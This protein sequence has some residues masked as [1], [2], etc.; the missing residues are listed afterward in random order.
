MISKN[1]IFAKL[2]LCAA[3]VFAATALAAAA[4]AQVTSQA[5]VLRITTGATDD[6]FKVVSGPVAGEVQLFEVPGAVDGALY[7]GVQRI[8][9][10]TN[11]G[12]DKITVETLSATVPQLAINAGAG[13]NE[14]VVLMSVPPSATP[15]TSTAAVLGGGGNDYIW[16]QATSAASNLNLVWDVFAGGGNNI[17]LAEALSDGPSQ[18]LSLDL[19]TQAGLGIDSATVNVDS[20]AAKLALL[21]DGGLGS[22][23]NQYAVNAKGAGASTTANLRTGLG[24]GAG[25]DNVLLELTEVGQTV[26][27]GGLSTGFGNDEVVAKFPQGLTGLWRIDTLAGAD[28]VSVFTQGAL[29]GAPRINTGD[30]ADLVEF[31]VFGNFAAAS[32]LSDGGPGIDVFH[33]V[34]ATVNF[35]QVN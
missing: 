17:I 10:L 18:Q 25:D 31:W 21:L 16:L 24:F 9:I 5:G 35:E 30:G 8:E 28:K 27:Q 14:I 1:R 6:L 7:T 13:D 15:V 32:P 19:T 20:Q 33:G 12:V 2:P 3:T 26:W 4:T 34:G 29:G 22:G 11:A 23:V